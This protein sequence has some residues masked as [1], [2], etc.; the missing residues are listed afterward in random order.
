MVEIVRAP[1]RERR[2]DA[3]ALD[4]PD[5]EA[6]VARGE[7]AGRRAF[8]PRRTTHPAPLA[9]L[10]AGALGKGDVGCDAGTDHDRVGVEP[11]T[12]ARDHARDMAVSLEALELVLAVHGDAVL[13][14]QSLEEGSRL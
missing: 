8:E 1:H 6:G 14:E 11:Q 12:R 2:A 5:R 9:D 4:V 7:H 13:F 10:Q 3:P